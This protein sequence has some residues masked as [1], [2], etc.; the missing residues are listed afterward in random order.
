MCYE[1]SLTVTLRDDAAIRRL[2]R[3]PSPPPV[4]LPGDEGTLFCTSIPPFRKGNT[5]FF[6][7]GNSCCGCGV[8]EDTGPADDGSWGRFVPLGFLSH[9]LRMEQVAFVEIFSWNDDGRVL[10]AKPPC[11]WL[12]W[13][14]FLE[15][16][17][18]GR[19]R[20]QI[21]YLIADS[22]SELSRTWPILERDRLILIPPR[23][24]RDVSGES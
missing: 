13:S 19:I 9:F 23:R 24:N 12:Y 15:I 3:A 17:D 4:R 5:R 2:M 16:N 1:T 6:R 21:L 14:E 8:W 11:R 18:R 22:R 7:V 20:D 10:P